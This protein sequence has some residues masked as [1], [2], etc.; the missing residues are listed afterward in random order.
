MDA[1]SYSWQ[2]RTSADGDSL[3]T[4]PLGLTELGFYWDAQF[5][6]TADIVTSDTVKVVGRTANAEDIFSRKN[7]HRAWTALKRRYPL[8]GA[9]I[10]SDARKEQVDFEVSQQIWDSEK[11][12]FSGVEDPTFVTIGS[13]AEAYE[14]GN[15]LNNGPR[16][17]SD[18]LLARLYILR[19]TDE[20]GVYHV[21]FHLAHLINDGMSNA[22]L[23]RIILDLLASGD[24][25]S[26]E[27]GWDLRLEERL[28]MVRATDSLDPNWR[29]SA[30]RRRWRRVI[31]R[32][33]AERRQ[34]ALKGGHTLPRNVTPSTAATPAKS[35]ETRISLPYELSSRIISTCRQNRI[36]F[37]HAHPVLGQLALSRVLH[38][39]RG[40]GK[41]SDAEWETRRRQPMHNGGP[42]NL[43]PFLDREWV[44]RGGDSEAMIA[45]SFYWNT[46]PF[47]PCAADGD[48]NPSFDKLLSRERFFYRCRMMKAQSDGFFRHPLFLEIA[49][50]RLPGRIERAR[51]GTLQ[52]MAKEGTL[53][54]ELE[55][56]HRNVFQIQNDESKRDRGV[57][58]DALTITHGG[59]PIGN[60]DQITPLE[61]PLPRIHPLSSRQRVPKI[62]P[63]APATDESAV[64]LKV[65][66]ARTLLHCRPTELYLG[67]ATSRKILHLNVFW[68]GNVYDTGL[69]HEWLD[70]VKNAAVWYLGGSQAGK[71]LAKL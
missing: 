4:R 41:I 53:T 29:L 42:A 54:K 25:E 69:V 30:P 20:P 21:F 37:G 71:E 67:A 7:V 33:M 24:I 61:Y 15:A 48:A 44:A 18:D 49:S 56:V 13:A 36:T 19:Q 50:A 10:V 2:R 14:F 47:M 52:W 45:I 11:P 59:S 60:V 66:D 16:Q 65:L 43:R 5:N 12:G 6:G 8:L 46:L 38:R 22:A 63:G 1:G 23:R 64:I 70:E 26:I 9:R 58:S 55:E 31:G 35:C 32:V 62:Q 17:L 39:L 40:Q 28:D 34:N 57:F 3:Y 51:S 68:D 27:A